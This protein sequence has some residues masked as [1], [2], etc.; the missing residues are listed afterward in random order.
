MRPPG[1]NGASQHHLEWGQCWQEWVRNAR[2]VCD[3]LN[4]DVTDVRLS[5]P[6]PSVPSLSLQPRV[7]PGA[8]FPYVHP[9]MHSDP[10]IPFC[11]HSPA[12]PVLG[13]PWHCTQTPH[14]CVALGIS[15]QSLAN[16]PKGSQHSGASLLCPCSPHSLPLHLWRFDPQCWDPTDTSISMV[17]AMHTSHLAHWLALVLLV[18]EPP[19]TGRDIPMAPPAWCPQVLLLIL[20]AVGWFPPHHLSQP[21]FAFS[22]SPFKQ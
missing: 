17:T 15:M 3:T 13:T 10:R 9:E 4:S 21:C 18:L 16:P 14:P 19:H 8:R 2:G 6:V 1:P 12:L 5:V 22:T 20:V 11:P 7:C